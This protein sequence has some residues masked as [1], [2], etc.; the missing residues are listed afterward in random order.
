V[1]LGARERRCQRGAAR[2]VHTGGQ[3]HAV[4]RAQPA[5]DRDHLRRRL[6]LA[7]D[8]LG[9]AGAQRALVIQRRVLQSLERRLGDPARGARGRDLAALHTAEQGR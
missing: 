5:R 3:H 1:H 8:H 4:A 9:E 2:G 6:A 7:E